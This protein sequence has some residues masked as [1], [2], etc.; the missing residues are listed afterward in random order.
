MRSRQCARQHGVQQQET[1]MT[2]YRASASDGIAWVTG[3][4]S[5]IGS[6]LALD[7]ASAGY[8]V[9]ATARSEDALTKLAAEGASGQGRIVPFPCDV[10]EAAAMERTV[11]AIERELGPIV[12]AVLNA[13]IYLPVRGDALVVDKFVDTYRVNVFG[14]IHGLVPVVHSMQERGFGHIAIIGSVAGYRGLPLAAAYGGTKASLNYL[15]AALKFDLDRMNIRIQIVNPG[16]VRTPATAGN[17]FRMPALLEVG[18]A[19]RRIIR[20]LE[21]G[22]FEVCFPRRLAWTLKVVDLLPHG[23]YFPLLGRAMGWN[24]RTMRREPPAIGSA[25]AERMD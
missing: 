13:G 17:K 9:A 7:L 12:L 22:G 18:E 4:S 14:V 10:T 25:E 3:A 15:A 21:K 5:G 20:G 11:A 2:L 6:Q 24:R 8:T 19:S 23:L 16:F 1:F